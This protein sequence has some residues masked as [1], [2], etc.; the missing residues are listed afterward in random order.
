MVRLKTTFLPSEE[1]TAKR[2]VYRQQL[3]ASDD[4]DPFL[5]AE[6]GL[7][8]PRAN[9]ELA[10]AVALEDD[11]ER[12]YAWARPGPEEAPENTPAVFLVVCGLLGLGRLGRPFAPMIGWP[13]DSS[14]RWLGVGMGD[15]LLA[16]V[17]PLVMYKG[18]GR[19]AGSTALGLNLGLLLLLLVLVATGIV[20]TFFPVMLVLGPLTLLQYASWRLRRGP[21]CTTRQ[22][23][24]VSGSR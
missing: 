4:W 3:R 7:P 16:T 13:A 24:R 23:R 21:E 22:F 8:G 5:Q 17:F 19:A 14:G 20:R 12:F 9:L 1:T 18:F 11:A 2:D 10:Y 15:L 6:S